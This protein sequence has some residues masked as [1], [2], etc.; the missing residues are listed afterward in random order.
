MELFVACVVLGI[1]YALISAFFRD[2]I[3]EMIQEREGLLFFGST[4]ITTACIALVSSLV[5]PLMFD[6]GWQAVLILVVAILF[7]RVSGYL[8]IYDQYAD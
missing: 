8:R 7:L 1:I 4:V 3:I 2:A 5:M 6:L